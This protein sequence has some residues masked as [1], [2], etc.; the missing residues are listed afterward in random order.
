MKNNIFFVV[1]FAVISMMFVSCNDSSSFN[2]GGLDDEDFR[3]PEAFIP[4]GE[5]TVD[6]IF[7]DD[8]RVSYRHSFVMTSEKERHFKG[9]EAAACSGQDWQTAAEEVVFT[10]N[11]CENEV[12]VNGWTLEYQYKGK[13]YT[14]RLPQ[15]ISLSVNCELSQVTV[16][17]APFYAESVAN[18]TL[19]LGD[20]KLA[21][22]ATLLVVEEEYVE[23]EFDHVDWTYEHNAFN[24]NAT[25]TNGIINVL[26]GNVAHFGDVYSNGEVR[27]EENVTY[28]VSNKFNFSAPAMEV[29]KLNDVIG[30]SYNFANGTVTVAGYAVKAVWAS[31]TVEGKVMHGDKDYASE[32]KACKTSAKTITFNSATSATIRFYDN[33]AADFAEV[34]VPVQVSEKVSLKNI[35]RNFIHKAFRKNATVSGKNIAIICDN[36]ASFVKEYSDGSKDAAKTVSYTWTNNFSFNAPAMVVENI[37]SVLNKTFNFN[38][39]TAVVE[40][41][42]ITVTFSNRAVSDIMFENKNY[43]SEAPVCK[44]EVKSITITSATTAEI[45]FEHDGE[46][47]IANVPVSIVEAEA[48]DGEIK[49]AWATDSYNGRTFVR[50]DLHVLAQKNGAY[51]VY[52]RTSKGEAWTVTSLSASEGQS[53]INS[54]RALAWIWNG[55]TQHMGTLECQKS[56]SAGYTIQYYLL[57]GR[58]ANNL[59]KSESTLNGKKFENPIHGTGSFK[60]GMWTISYDGNTY[61]FASNN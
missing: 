52:S 18:Y 29:D 60:N 30:K 33:D 53:V 38:N 5:G 61:H 28:S 47:V 32:I 20:V 14:L 44:I 10:Y 15:Y 19:S 40:G 34:S 42:N 36:E 49:G 54:G 24:R 12:K 25:Y 55:S 35:I 2:A 9:T 22:C 6:I 59:G 50:T 51:V 57:D 56:E 4:T 39:G 17:E 23:P 58:L 46:K 48:I 16:E 26:C 43:K 13:T 37:N 7:D 41:K 21:S 8:S 1:L 11:V 3:T 27:N 31:A 45:T